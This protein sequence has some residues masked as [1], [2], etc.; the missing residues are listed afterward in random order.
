MD[1]TFDV[2]N[3][4][5]LGRDGSDHLLLIVVCEGLGIRGTYR[6][7]DVMVN[8]FGFKLRQVEGFRRILTLAMIFACFRFLR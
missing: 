6:A 3:L 7:L 4:G 5:L 2:I 8:V 1:K